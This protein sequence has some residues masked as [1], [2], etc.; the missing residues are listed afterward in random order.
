MRL[1]RMM[2][3]ASAARVKMMLYTSAP[4]LTVPVPM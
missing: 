2:P 1:N 4:T 3:N